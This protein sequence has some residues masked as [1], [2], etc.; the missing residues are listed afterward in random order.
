MRVVHGQ[1][2]CKKA[3][4]RA[5]AQLA[6]LGAGA[7]IRY[8]VQHPLQLRAGKIGVRDQSRT[9]AQHVA[10][11]VALQAFHQRRGT[12]ALPNDGIA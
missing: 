10:Q 1:V 3:V 11:A 2:P 12:A 5:E 9:V 4:H 7:R 8:A 6:A